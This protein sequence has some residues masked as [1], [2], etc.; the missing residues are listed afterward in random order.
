MKH[1]IYTYTDTAPYNVSALDVYNGVENKSNTVLL[2]SVEISSKDQQSSLLMPKACVRIVSTRFNVSIT[3]LTDNGI[4][5]TALLSPLLSQFNPIFTNNTLSVKFEKIDNNAEESQRVRHPNVLSVLRVIKDSFEATGNEIFITGTFSFDLL[6]C[7][8]DLASVPT[9]DNTCP[10]YVFYVAETLMVFDHINKTCTLSATAFDKAHCDSVKQSMLSLKNITPSP[11]PQNINNGKTIC[12]TPS[13]SDSAFKKSVEICQDYIK[14]GDAFQI[15]PSRVFSI[16]CENPL[17]SYG[18]LKKLNP[19][20]YM[21]YVCDADFITFGASPESALKY[22]ASDNVVSLYPIAGT[23]PR[24]K[25]ADGTINPDLDTRLELEMRMDDKEVSEHIML[26]DL[27]RNDIARISEPSTRIVS[28]LMHIDKYSHVQHLVSEVQGQ[29][30]D[31]YDCLHAYQMCM[32]MGTLTGAPKVRA[33]EIIREVENK[34]RGSYGG[35]I[36]YI[37][38]SGDMDTC[39]TIRSA[40]VKNGVAHIGAGA[41]VVLQSNP[42]AEADETRLKAMSVLTAI[43]QTHGYTLVTEGNIKNV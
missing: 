39:I 36:G 35:A 22:T 20:P 2:E 1:K 13:V 10:N 5:L 40:F 37:N 38:A 28:S 9:G 30:K 8:E 29:L 25:N 7:I 42:Q 24:G 16:P 14:A 19:S 26:V 4:A 12:P 43:A 18:T 6:D 23:R 32:N 33:S 31:T 34:S 11:L 27:A 15:V 21:F 3:P 17:Q 41:G